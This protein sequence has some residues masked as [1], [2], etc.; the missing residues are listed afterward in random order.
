MHYLPKV[1][2]FILLLPAFN[3]D[4]LDITLALNCG[5]IQINDVDPDLSCGTN[6]YIFTSTNVNDS[7][8]YD[9]NTNDDS[10]I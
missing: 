4:I 3:S 7:T 10:F 8:V 2:L 6:S 1:L 5:V 9:P